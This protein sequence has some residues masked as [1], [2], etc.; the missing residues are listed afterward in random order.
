MTFG[1]EGLAKLCLLGFF[2]ALRSKKHGTPEEHGPHT[3]RFCATQNQRYGIH[4]L[5]IWC[6]LVVVLLCA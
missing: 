1:F 3:G 6:S 4:S 5:C 2:A